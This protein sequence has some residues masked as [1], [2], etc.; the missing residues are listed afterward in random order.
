MCQGA[1]NGRSTPHCTFGT[2]LISLKLLELESGNF[3]HNYAGSNTLFGYEYCSARG[4]ARGAAPLLYQM[5][6]RV[7]CVPYT[8]PGGKKS[9]PKRLFV[10]TMVLCFR[11]LRLLLVSRDVGT[12]Q[13]A[14]TQQLIL[15]L[16]MGNFQRAQLEVSNFNVQ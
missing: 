6:G 3:T 5:Y 8:P 15:L 4:R 1:Y 12:S 11:G 2:P 14:D 9:H 13:S 16:D 10:I 7:C